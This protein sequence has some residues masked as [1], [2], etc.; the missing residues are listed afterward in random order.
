[1]NPI[2]RRTFLAALGLGGSSLFLPSLLRRKSARAAGGP[3][4]RLILVGTQH[5]TL[6]DE[7]KMR[8]PGTSEAS[9]WEADLTTTDVGVFSPLLSELYAHRSR[10][11]VLDGLAVATGWSDPMGG[12]NEHDKGQAGAFTGA[13]TVDGTK[14]SGP[15]VDQIV[16]EAIRLPDRYSSL[17]F[18]VPWGPYNGGVIYLGSGN[19]APTESSPQAA[20]DRLFPNGGGGGGEPTEADLIRGEQG[21]VLD[22]VHAQYDA[23]SRRLSSDDRLKLEQHR[24]LIRDLEMRLEGLS[25]VSCGDVPPPGSV[26]G[27]VSQSDAF[28]DLMAAAL[29]CDLTRVISIQIG[30]LPDELV[31]F[32]GNDLHNDVV[33]HDDDPGNRAIMMTYHTWQMRWFGRLLDRLASV[34]EGGGTLLDNTLVVWGGELASGSHAFQNWPVVMA[35]GGAGFAM[36]RYLYWP[37]TTPAPSGGYLNFLS[38]DVVG[39]PHNKLLVSIA[40]A[41]GS[42]ASSVGI[43]SYA[44]VGGATVNTTGELEGLR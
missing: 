17:E 1:M 33:H 29:S 11:L 40:R 31:G 30:T 7:W 44:G 26:S 4:R 14:S 13:W 38:D 37:R 35:G 16:A 2:Q 36:G 6:Y 20:Y 43:T 12:G 24:D 41:F 28:I 32:T 42:D 5:G 3:P 23:L 34:A 8:P 27:F 22:L 18:A 9:A 19:P 15:S 25:T 39:I 21:S 10:L